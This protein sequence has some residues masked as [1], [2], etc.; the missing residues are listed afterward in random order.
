MLQMVHLRPFLHQGLLLISTILKIRQIIVLWEWLIT[1]PISRCKIKKIND[2][3]N[4]EHIHQLKY[5]LDKKV[6]IYNSQEFIEND[7][8]QI[9]H[10]FSKKE[11]VELAAFLTATITWGQRKSIIKSANFLMQLMENTP[12]EFV[13]Q[14]SEKEIECLERFVYR[15]FNGNDCIFFIRSLRNIY[16]QHGGLESVFSKGYQYENSI[17]DA[18]GY[19]REI[20]FS[21]PHLSRVEKHVSDALKNASAKRLNMFLRWMVR[22]DDNGV[23]FGLWKQLPSSALLLPLDVHTGNVGRALDLLTRKQ[24]D[25]KAVL[26]ITQNLRVLDSLDPVKY[27]FALFGMGI[28]GYMKSNV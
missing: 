8:I 7:P 19:F 17:L 16:L 5:I 18:L 26:E 13:M 10:S 23:D 27:D 25:M 4:S 14:A 3:I 9:P 28:D 6:E 24:N 12:Y 11:D 15:T 2:L 22:Q 21:I 1:E 20:F